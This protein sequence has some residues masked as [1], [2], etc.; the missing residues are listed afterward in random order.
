MHDVTVQLNYK[1]FIDSRFPLT[2]STQALY[3][4]LSVTFHHL[5]A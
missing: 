2:M 4:K 3:Q 5:H 1:Q